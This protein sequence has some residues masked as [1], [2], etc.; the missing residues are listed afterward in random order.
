MPP[1]ENAILRSGNCRIAWPQSRSWTARTVT[2]VESTMYSSKL[3]SG[4]L[5][6][7]ET[8]TDVQAHDHVEV[9]TSTEKKGSHES[10]W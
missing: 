8:L 4:R 9:A 3:M 6:A 7:F 10:E 2:W 5:I 1:S